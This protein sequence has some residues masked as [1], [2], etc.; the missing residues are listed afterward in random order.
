MKPMPPPDM[1][2]SIQKP[3]KSSP[4]AFSETRAIKEFREMVGGPGDDCLQRAAEIL[5][6]EFSQ[7]PNI[8]LRE[9]H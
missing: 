1:P 4:K 5:S 2:P 7:C 3:Q 8:A 9:E 6:G